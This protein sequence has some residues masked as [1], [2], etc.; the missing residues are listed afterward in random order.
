MDRSGNV[1]DREGGSHESI[2]LRVVH[3]DSSGIG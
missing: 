2:G 3:I 1:V